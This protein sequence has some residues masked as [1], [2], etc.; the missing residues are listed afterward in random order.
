VVGYAPAY[1]PCAP[2]VSPDGQGEAEG[3][4]GG[5]RS[6]FGLDRKPEA[7]AEPAAPPAAILPEPMM[8][9][10]MRSL[11]QPLALT[12]SACPGRLREQRTTRSQPRRRDTTRGAAP[13]SG[14]RRRQFRPDTGASGASRASEF[15]W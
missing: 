11:L 15:W 7:P 5:W 14:S 1:A 9:M 2:A 8:L 6:W 10:N 12:G 4:G 13:G 3:E